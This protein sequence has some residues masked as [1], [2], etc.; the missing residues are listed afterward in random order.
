MIRATINGLPVE[1]PEGA[2]ILSAARQVGAKIPTLCKHPDLKAT[3]SCG[4][5]VVRAEHTS[6]MLHACCTPLAEGMKITTEDP[7]IIRYRRLLVE[8]ILSEHP[9]E[10]LTCGRNGDCELQ[11][12]AAD[13]GLRE[14]IPGR[15]SP[16]PSIDKSTGSIVVDRRKCILCGRCVQVC[17]QVQNVWALTV[18]GRGMQSRVAT[19]PSVDLGGSPCVRCG[20][21]AAHCP[22]GAIVEQDGTAE[23]WDRLS[24]PGVHCA[25]QI[26]PAVRV[27]IGETF[28]FP[29]GANLTGKIYAALRRMGFKAVFDTNFGADLTVIEEAHEFVERFVRGN[30]VLPLI[31]SCCP[32]WVEF[33]QEYHSDMIPHVS[34]CKSPHMMVGALAKT[35]YREKTEIDPA[36][37][38]MV[39]VMPCTAKKAELFRSKEMSSSG[40][41][42]VDISLTTRELARMIKQA[43]IDLQTLPEEQPDHLMGAYTGAGT[44][45]G[46]TG[47]V[48]E[49]A[50]RTA[51]YLVTK[52]D[53]GRA[54]LQAVRGLKGVKEGEIAVADKTVRIAVVHG[55]GNVG[56]VLDRIRE[57]RTSGQELPYHFIEVMACPGG[58]VGGGG[59]PYG[60]TDE[61]RKQRAAG[62]YQE[63][64]V[65]PWRCA[66]QNSYVQQLYRDFL[67]EPL[68]GKAELLL[69]TSYQPQPV[70]QQ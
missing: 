53:P 50:L 48:M 15:P 2:T 23:V 67:G 24:D 13:L 27:A 56:G 1:A 26:A 31:T 12:A 8:L 47:G 69:H 29:P 19:A 20:Q 63:D 32:A 55:L 49:A 22:T 17:Q 65:A 25:V 51:S 45:F 6:K 54:D 35:Y 21:C 42:D 37:I 46:A 7:T 9:N 70:Y 30:S 58:C 3:A 66:H 64:H 52:Q 18:V 57:A 39:S 14:V 28:G 36:R 44:I 16:K 60:V 41:R 43:G 11:S 68:G 59:Q 38:Y 10:C 40:F 62:L 5:C 4:I 34:S 33:M 61:L